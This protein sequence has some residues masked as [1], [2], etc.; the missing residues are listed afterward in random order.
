MK[1]TT[2]ALSFLLSQ[3]IVDGQIAIASQ[4]RVSPTDRFTKPSHA[5]QHR[6]TL[7]TT[8]VLEEEGSMSLA[9]SMSIM[10]VE[11]EAMDMIEI[12][13]AVE[14][15]VDSKSAKS[16][17]SKSSKKLPNISGRYL[18]LDA[19]SGNPSNLY[20]SC[21]GKNN[22]CDI[23]LQ[24]GRFSNCDE[25]NPNPFNG[26]GIAKN[27]PRDQ[28]GDFKIKLYCKKQGETEI[29]LFGMPSTYLVGNIEFL[30]DGIIRRN[31]PSIVYYKDVNPVVKDMISPKKNKMK[32]LASK[33]SSV[34][35]PLIGQ[36][37]GAD[38]EDGSGQLL[39]LLCR[40]DDKLCDIDLFDVSFSTCKDINDLEFFG[41]VGVAR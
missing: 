35:P 20:L 9:T 10:A 23:I 36:Y 18:G 7:R 4:R 19:E 21:D 27:I 3:Y 28:L 5:K 37:I 33:T 25:D 26:L 17:E 15:V 11:P 34:S 6:R 29:D 40:E 12:E 14:P 31:G 39:T 22:L 13:P 1:K 30:S 2:I 16:G 8:R 32:N 24:P 38:T 41:G